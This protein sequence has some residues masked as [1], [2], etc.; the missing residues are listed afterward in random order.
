M[1]TKIAECRNEMRQLVENTVASGY[2]LPEPI[3]SIMRG[4]K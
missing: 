2:G 4:S 1:T 3:R